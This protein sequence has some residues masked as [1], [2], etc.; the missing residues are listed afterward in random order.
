MNTRLNNFLEYIRII[1]VLAWKDVR[2]ALKNRN[3]L[4][5]IFTAGMIIVF[6]KALPTLSTGGEPPSVLVYDAGASALTVLLEESP[7]LAVRTQFSTEAAMIDRLRDGDI[8][9]LG[10][11]IPAGYD[12]QRETGPAPVLQGYVMYWLDQDEA[13]A[14]K[15]AAAAE[16]SRLAGMPVSI[17]IEGNTIFEVPEKDG[18]GGQAAMATIFALIMIGITLVPNILMDEKQARTLDV[19]MVSP[20]SETQ[21]ASGKALAGLLYTSAVAALALAVNYRL[22]MHWG[23]AVAAILLFGMLAVL[24]GLILG[25]LVETRAQFQLWSWVLILPLIM[26]LIVYLLGDL[27]PDFLQK[28]LPVFPSATMMIL[29]RYSFAEP[30]S[31][32]TPL[33]GL[34][35]LLVW[36]TAELGA[37]S[38]LLRRRDRADKPIAAANGVKAG[39][40]K[41]KESPAPVPS[42]TP[43]TARREEPEPASTSG[44]P[45]TT[46]DHRR[47]RRQGRARGGPQPFVPLDHGRSVG[48]RSQ[49]RGPAPAA[50]VEEPALG[51][52]VR[53]GK[54]RGRAGARG[55]RG[56]PGGDRPVARGNGGDGREILRHLGGDRRS[57]GFRP[58]FGR[59]GPDGGDRALD[60]SGEG[61][62]DDRL[63]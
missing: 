47:D 44:Y 58:A 52:G 12:P 39:D 24:L 5:L 61:E 56:L 42:T 54:I 60:G 10:L 55:P 26:P 20:A 23:L 17:S 22:V 8:P 36:V 21:I 34:G 15:N 16:I 59:G 18:A 49:R 50:G 19:L 13:L 14:L 33:L 27:L 41:W 29:M 2:D 31:W 35:W 6:Y 62:P 48:D 57:A 11:I 63:L 40:R 51:G 46:A 32:G 43:I 4:V 25:S 9:E 30:I 3:I 37:V 28:I 1:R 45:A 7:N 38:W 53:R